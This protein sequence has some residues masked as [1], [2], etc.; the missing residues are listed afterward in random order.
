MN[1]FSSGLP[2]QKCKPVTSNPQVS[3]MVCDESRTLGTILSSDETICHAKPLA[4]ISENFPNCGSKRPIS[5]LL[6]PSSV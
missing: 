4:T 2:R 1:A 6:P 3:P 5:R